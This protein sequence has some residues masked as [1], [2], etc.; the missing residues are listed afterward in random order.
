MTPSGDTTLPHAIGEK[1]LRPKLAEAIL[2]LASQLILQRVGII[3]K[4]HQLGNLETTLLE[5][6]KQFQFSSPMAL[7]KTLEYCPAN[8]A[9]MK[10]LI[11]RITVGESFFFRDDKQIAFLR[12]IWIPQTTARKRHEQHHS[13]RLWSAGCS[14]GQEVVTLAIL[15]REAMLDVEQWQ[16]NLLGTDINSEALHRANQGIYP[17]WSF[18]TI[19][20]EIKKRYFRYCGKNNQD[21]WQIKK[22]LQDMITYAHLNLIEED[23]LTYLGEYQVMDL[24]LCRNVFI[25]F[26]QNT[27]EKVLAKLVSCLAPGGYLILGASDMILHDIPGCSIHQYDENIYYQ[28]NSPT[29]I[30]QPIT[31]PTAADELSSLP[32]ADSE[33]SIITDENEKRLDFKGLHRTVSIPK[34]LHQRA[35]RIEAGTI[36]SGSNRQPLPTNH[37]YTAE[38]VAKHAAERL[39]SA[40]MINKQ[41]VTLIHQKAWPNVVEMLDNPAIQNLMTPLLLQF[42]AKALANLGNFQ[43]TIEL[44]QQSISL[45]STD[46]HVYLIMGMALLE[47]GHWVKAERAFRQALFLDR[48]F[49]ECHFQL[50]HLLIQNDR[51]EAGIKSLNKTLSLAKEGK[52]E[53]QVHN[54]SGMRFDHFAGI[55]KAELAMYSKRSV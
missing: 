27:I 6:Q 35:F 14:D 38:H 13:L 41:V 29:T 54:A 21:L 4:D 7:L 28:K 36:K 34:Q 50:G 33:E 24:I 37:A 26:D 12:N 53:W 44:C 31:R 52:P 25:Y 55:L 49:M 16:I 48:N 11:S 47:A 5:A 23:Y 22:T 19:N 10:F 46:K 15:L 51:T 18:R 3:I 8:A 1:P 42:K 30:T 39:L 40:E 43:Q 17:K 45:A 32:I 9:E 20:E 2:Q